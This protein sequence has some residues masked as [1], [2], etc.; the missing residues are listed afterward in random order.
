M[1]KRNF[2]KLIEPSNIFAAFL[3]SPTRI[4]VIALT[5]IM[6]IFPLYWLVLCAF[7]LPRDVLANPP[8]FFPE[9]IT[10]DNFTTLFTKNNIAHIASNSLIVSLVTTVISTLFGSMAAYAI[11]RGSLHRKIRTACAFWFLLQKMYPAI[12]TAIPVYY[13][14]RYLHLL[15]KLAGLIIMN[16]SFNIPL[17]IWIMIGFYDSI[18]HSIEESAQLDGCNM[19][20]IF[21][22]I[23]I[24][25]TQTGMVA[26]AILTFIG[27][28]NE[29]LFAVIL[30]IKNSKT[31]PVVVAGFITDKGMDWGPMSASA[32]IIIIP[33]VV[34]VMLLQKNFVR[35]LTMGA[36]KE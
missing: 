26:A 9:F 15:D 8:V 28:W 7:K 1:F 33:V 35:G 34:I 24:P 14:L 13:V 3:G 10:F 27:A 31:L 11:S 6:I 4:I 17:I 30:T 16:V 19:A 36:V 25:T 22:S 2:K 32:L 20:R 23:I 12:A 21:F 5:L 29:F 18:P